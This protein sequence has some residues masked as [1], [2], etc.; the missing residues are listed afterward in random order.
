M[1]AGAIGIGTTG[2]GAGVAAIGIV[3]GTAAAGEARARF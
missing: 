1:A 3:T 2:I